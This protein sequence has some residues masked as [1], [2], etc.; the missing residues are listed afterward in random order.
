MNTQ[1]EPELRNKPFLREIAVPFLSSLTHHTHLRIITTT[2]FS[3]DRSSYDKK[4]DPVV[5][6]TKEW[7]GKNQAKMRGYAALPPDSL[8]EFCKEE[9]TLAVNAATE[10]EK[11]V[12]E[13]ALWVVD[14][15]L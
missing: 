1:T 9:Q 6:S 5:P 7:V 11:S 2:T 12:L 13:N 3:K 10:G 14:L 15:D 8:E 4:E